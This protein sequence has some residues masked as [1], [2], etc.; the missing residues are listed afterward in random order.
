MGVTHHFAFE[1]D[2]RLRLMREQLVYSSKASRRGAYAA[3]VLASIIA[4]SFCAIT[5]LGPA[6]VENGVLFCLG[7]MAWSICALVSDAIFSRRTLTDAEV[8]YWHL[9]FT[10]LHGA[11]GLAWAMAVFAFWMPD[12]PLNQMAL[13]MLCVLAIGNAANEHGESLLFV[14]TLSVVHAFVTSLGFLLQDTEIGSVAM[15][16]LPTSIVWY[17]FMTMHAQRRFR[18]LVTTRL[19]NEDLVSEA[20]ASR[21]E[22]LVLKAKAESA[23]NAKSAF[24][25]NMSHELRTPLNAIIGFSQIVRD[26]LFGPLN[27]ARYKDY[28]V[29]IEGSGQHLLGIINDILDIAKIESGKTELHREWVRPES[30]VEDAIRVVSGHPS[31]NGVQLKTDYAH[32]GAAIH[33]DQRMLRQSVINLLSNAV[34]HTP[35]DRVVSVRTEMT[36]SYALRI[37]VTDEGQGIAPHMVERVFEAFE[38]ADNSYA[39]D[40]QGTGLGL[41]LVRAFV[42]AHHGRVW[43]ESQVGKGTRAIIEL[44]D[45]R[46]ANDGIELAA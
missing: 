27:N 6:P 19:R 13:L 22:A 28:M 37:V 32:A 17:G 35:A 44:P 21:D 43:L 33:G 45:V 10:A 8:P 29:D 1:N 34:K 26:E 20:A 15:I 24:L 7:I 36:P 39:R 41:A 23:S 12:N 42:T 38:Q 3:V 40:K 25:A 9:A 46:A 18:E 14:A 4:F 30:V 31:A 5:P 11:N 2:H 16:V